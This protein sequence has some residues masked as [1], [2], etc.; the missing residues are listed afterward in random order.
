MCKTEF[1]SY[2]IKAILHVLKQFS[3]KNQLKVLL[4]NSM[5]RYN[6]PSFSLLVFY[7][8]IL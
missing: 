8:T 5:C 2:L 4:A 1:N 6:S 7:V 3:D